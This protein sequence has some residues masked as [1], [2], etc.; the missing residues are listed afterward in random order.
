VKEFLV[1]KGRV[2]H[3]NQEEIEQNQKRGEEKWGKGNNPGGGPI[4]GF[5]Q[6]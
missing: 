4:K 3:L 5:L 2:A 6:A 1:G